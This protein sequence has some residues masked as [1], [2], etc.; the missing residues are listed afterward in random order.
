MDVEHGFGAWIQAWQWQAG[1]SVPRGLHK[2]CFLHCYCSS[3]DSS[4]SESSSAVLHFFVPP[5]D[6][7]LRSLPTNIISLHIT[8]S[9]RLHQQ[10]A[11]VV[12]MPM[13]TRSSAPPATAA[14]ANKATKSTQARKTS[15]AKSKSVYGYTR[16]QCGHFLVSHTYRCFAGLI[17]GDSVG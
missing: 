17:I 15:Q 2:Y 5:N 8:I 12:T 9:T 6:Y 13:N 16:L 1:D 4:L 14:V 3:V 7:P 11:F 10:V